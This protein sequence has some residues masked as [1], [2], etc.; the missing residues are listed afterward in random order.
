MFFEAN[1]KLYGI[2]NHVNL[3]KIKYPRMKLQFTNKS[4]IDIT[5]MATQFFL[6]KFKNQLLIYL[7]Y[8]VLA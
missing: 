3:A 8:F 2:L 5:T 1:K 6:R 4:K 7:P